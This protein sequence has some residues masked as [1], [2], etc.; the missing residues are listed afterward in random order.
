MS[1]RCL[2]YRFDKATVPAVLEGL[3]LLTA[4]DVAKAQLAA[5]TDPD[6][7]LTACGIRSFTTAQVDAALAKSELSIADRL[8]VKLELGRHELMPHA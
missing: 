3:G 7:P 8:T 5:A 1:L 2:P 6:K 4:L